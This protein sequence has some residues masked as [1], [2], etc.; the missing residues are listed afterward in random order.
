VGWPTSRTSEASCSESQ[1]H[2]C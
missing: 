1:R 2:V